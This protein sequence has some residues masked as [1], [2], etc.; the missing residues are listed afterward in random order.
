MIKGRSSPGSAEG[1][2]LAWGRHR[3]RRRGPSWVCGE[4]HLSYSLSHSA[5]LTHTLSLSRCSTHTHSLTLLHSHALSLSSYHTHG[6]PDQQYTTHSVGPSHHFTLTQQDAMAPLCNSQ[7]H[8]RRGFDSFTGRG[9]AGR[10]LC[11]EDPSHYHV[12]DTG[13][14]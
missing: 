7:P 12:K 1:A 14:R 4:N 11:E 6:Q 10:Y 9:L 13:L 2:R 3:W 5:P 8:E